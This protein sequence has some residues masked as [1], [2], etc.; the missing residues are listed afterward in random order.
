MPAAA[1][2][3]PPADRMDAPTPMDPAVHTGKL[4]NGL[5]YY[6]LNHGAPARRAALWLAV[7]AGS[8]EE[9]DD[10]RG[11]AHFVEHVAFD[12][13]RR[14]P[15][16]AII[17]F[18][19]RAGMTFGP[20]INAY[21]GFDQTVYQLTVPTD[22]P[23]TL[24][25]G[26]DML[27]DIAGDVTFDPAEIDNERRVVLEEWR[28]RQTAAAR[29]DAEETTTVLR[30]SRYAER[31][32]IG[33]TGTIA[34]ATPAALRRYY[35]AWYRPETMAVIAV[36]D[37][38]VQQVEAEIRARFGDFRNPTPAPPRPSLRVP[39]AGSLAISATTDPE[40][41]FTTVTAVHRGEHPVYTTER[42]Y[43][44]RLVDDLARMMENERLAKVRDDADH[45]FVGSEV[46]LGRVT[47]GLDL[48]VHRVAVK[49]GQVAEAVAALYFEVEQTAA[50]GF[51]P[52]ELERARRA[53]LDWSQLSLLEYGRLTVSDRAEEI[54]RNFTEHEQMPGPELELAWVRELLP[55]I[56]LAEVNA[57]VR[58]RADDP[59]Q[60]LMI[61]GPPPLH[62][63]SDEELRGIVAG[64][65]IAGGQ[66]AP[67][68]D[69]IPDKPL[70][71]MQPIPGEVVATAADPGAGAIVWTLDNGVRVVVK[72]TDFRR[73]TVSVVG[74]QSGG[75]SV[76]GDGDFPSARFAGEIVDQSGAGDFTQRDLYMLLG[77]RQLSVS[78]G[79]DE[80]ECTVTAEARPDN[81]ETMLQLLYL[82]LTAPRED[83]WAFSIWKGK[84]LEALRHA[85][86]SPD[87]R[88]DDAVAALA[89]G[90]HPRRA[91]VTAETIGAVDEHLAYTTWKTAFSDFGAFTF[92]IVGNVDPARLRPLVERYL[93]TLPG[94]RW[95]PHW[96]DIGVDYPAGKVEKTIA[97][98]QAPR[99]RVS[100]SFGA[101]LPFSLDAERDARVLET[102]LQIRLREVLRDGLGGVYSVSVAAKLEREPVARRTLQ[103]AFECGPENVDRLR[104]AVFTALEKIGR[105]GVEPE[106]LAK[107]AAQLRRQ[108]QIDLRDNDW[109]SARLREAYRFGQD[110]AAA[111]D[112]E[113]LLA[114]IT[115]ADVQASVR[116]ILADQAYVLAVLRPDRPGGALSPASQS[117]APASGGQARANQ[118]LWSRPGL[119]TVGP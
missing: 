112:V 93:A 30:G 43:R 36:G 10:Q 63:P 37:F 82:R 81:L 21:T 7:D 4:P 116:R 47:R 54:V 58:A 95:A 92:V 101:R 75:T 99:S 64:G 57:F 115:S 89:N 67:F 45:P 60:L 50:S 102:L 56:S 53:L 78:L 74:W 29:G 70:L 90:N 85:A 119:G 16:H 49:E 40:A 23:G 38:D 3:P 88:F 98:G 106:I 46:T 15:K 12:G 108:H 68:R 114:R 34:A 26:L 17:G 59:G 96:K 76:V 97:A 20:D 19:E 18:L 103:I 11:L 33:L 55:T 110:F 109:W 52:S 32:P 61:S 84:R 8:V 24:T 42:A 94:H 1:A 51:L 25:E 2:V 111:N 41:R 31:L 22:E 86:G 79:L 107:V 48:H 9:G 72:P 73:D 100:L 80:L 27:R 13:T 118:D 91:A 44:G 87:Q 71:E 62:R 117:V 35:Q 14:F 39:H 77:G 83:S 69:D 5:T 28:T 105:D 113:P 66:R 65:F 104:G 6:V